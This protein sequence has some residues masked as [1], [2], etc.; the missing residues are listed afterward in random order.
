MRQTGTAFDPLETRREA[1]KEMKVDLGAKSKEGRYVYCAVECRRRRSFGHIGIEESEVYTI[2]YRD[3]GAVVHD[4]PLEPYKGNEEDVKGYVMTHQDVVDAMWEEFGTVLPM[5]FDTIVKGEE[6][7][8]AWLRDEYESFKEKLAG[9]RGKVEVAV[10]VFWDPQVIGQEIAEKNEEIRKLREE[11]ETK[12]RGMAY[13]YKM[14]MEDALKKE[15]EARAEML[16]RKFYDSMKEHAE[17]VWVEKPKKVRGKQMLM[18]LSLLIR[19]GEVEALGRLLGKVKE[20]KGL[21]VRFTGPWPPY[22]FVL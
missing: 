7:V 9:F 17:D 2:P 14:K 6:K 22:S 21:E 5:R 16:F 15:M 12:P 4:C 20:M 3:I 11:M 19:K 1:Q 18:N 8:R 13:F 10:K